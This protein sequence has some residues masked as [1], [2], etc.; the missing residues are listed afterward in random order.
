MSDR[1]IRRIVVAGLLLFAVSAVHGANRVSRHFRAA[2]PIPA[3][4]NLTAMSPIDEARWISANGARPRH[5]KVNV[6]YFV[7]TFEK[8]AEEP[9][10][11]DVSADERFWLFLD[12][13]LIA[14]GPHRG[15]LEHWLYQS[16]ALTLDPGRHVLKAIVT[17]MGEAAPLA[18]LTSGKARFI[19]KASGSYDAVLTTGKGDWQ[20]GVL[21]TMIAC[22]PGGGSWGGGHQVQIAGTS[23]WNDVPERLRPAACVGRPIDKRHA[24]GV[25]RESDLRLFPSTLPDQ[26]HARRRIGTAGDAPFDALVQRDQPLTIPPHTR[27]EYVWDLG[28]YYC[29]YPRLET[30]GG[31][32]AAVRWGWTESLVLPEGA[33]D[34]GKGA[35]GNRARREGKVVP[36]LFQD[37]FLC[38]GRADAQFTTPWWRCGRWSVIRIETADEPLTLRRLVVEETRYPLETLNDFAASDP[39][40]K[41]INRI[42]NRAMQMCAHEMFFDCPFIEQQMYGGDSRVDWLVAGIMNPD[43][44][45]VRHSIGLFDWSRFPDGLLPMNAPSRR[46]QESGTYSLCIPM[47]IGDYALWRDDLEGLRQMLP[48]LRH[49]LSAIEQYE[50]GEGI[51]ERLPGWC[52]LDWGHVPGRTPALTS[53]I[54]L[55]WALALRRAADAEEAAGNMDF[56]EGLRKHAVR[57]AKAVVDRCWDEARGLLADDPGGAVFTEHAQALAVVTEALSPERLARVAAALD[58][59]CRDGK[60]ELVRTGIYFSH[61][62]FAAYMKLE[63]PDLFLKRLDIWRQAVDNGFATTPEENWLGTRSDCHAWSAHPA[64]HFQTGLCGIRPTSLRFATVEIAPQPGPLEWLRTRFPHPKG[65][66]ACDLTFSGNAVRGTVT[67]PEGL[68]AVFRWKGRTQR[69]QAGT[70]VLELQP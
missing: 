30:A 20:C 50:N 3:N 69:L 40:L 2:P 35:K 62:L 52:F 17:Q 16:Y 56:A 55:H 14:R 12:G 65:V 24:C 25:R 28:N 49:T 59:N 1:I 44:R 33:V 67:L 6:E 64:F 48:G 26:L 9:L 29:L 70:N 37:T 10:T 18:Q 36:A 39:C 32:G 66:I 34:P 19:L 54:T 46:R 5:E 15:T 13:E 38:D 21:G 63:R 31:K 60:A 7:C 4:V 61:Y 47:A 11:I 8:V 22:G 57:C 41:E 43:P 51:L 58:R 68:P 23:F 27:R 42:C 53:P 45:L